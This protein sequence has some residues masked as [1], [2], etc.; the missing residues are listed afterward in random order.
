MKIQLYIYV[1]LVTFLLNACD[2]TRSIDEIN[3]LNALEAEKA[4]SSAP[5][6]ELALTGL[7]SSFHFTSVAS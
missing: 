2:L 7:Y 1:I 6:A 3:P 5:A 4:I